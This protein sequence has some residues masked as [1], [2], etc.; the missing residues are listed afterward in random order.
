MKKI[1]L[2]NGLDAPI[3]MDPS[4]LTL[5]YLSMLVDSH[6]RLFKLL[7]ENYHDKIE[8][9]AKEARNAYNNYGLIK[10]AISDLNKAIMDR[11][12]GAD[13]DGEV[14]SSKAQ[15]NPQE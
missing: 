7:D 10:N 15:E 14:N 1:L 13:Q 9:L 12:S 6:Q 5:E 11:T 4:D 2:F 3:E 8:Y